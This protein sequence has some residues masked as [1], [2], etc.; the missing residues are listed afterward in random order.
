M[1][2]YVYTIYVSVCKLQM[3]VDEEWVCVPSTPEI[4]RLNAGKP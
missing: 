4:L 3:D 2:I 1:Y